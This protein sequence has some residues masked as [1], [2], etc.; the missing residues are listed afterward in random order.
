MKGRLGTKAAVPNKVLEVHVF[1]DL[2]DRFFVNKIIMTAP[3]TTLGLIEE[4]PKVWL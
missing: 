4:A 1:L 2:K 3:R